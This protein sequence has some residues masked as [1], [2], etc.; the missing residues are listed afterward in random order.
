MVKIRTKIEQDLSTSRLIQT[1]SDLFE[2][3]I[4]AGYVLL[5]VCN[6]IEEYVHKDDLPLFERLINKTL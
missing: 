3:Y 6:G 4:A 2:S 1:P 5:R